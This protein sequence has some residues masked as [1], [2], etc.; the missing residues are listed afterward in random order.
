MHVQKV[1]T[2]FHGL[3]K[4]RNE[5]SLTSTGSSVNENPLARL[6]PCAVDERRVAR[7]HRHVQSRRGV[8]T[9]RGRYL[10]DGAVVDLDL[11][12]VR[13]L[14]GAKDAGLTRDESAAFRDRRVGGDDAGELGARDP[15]EGRFEL[16]LA[17]DLQNCG[18]FVRVSEATLCATS[19]LSWRGL[20]IKDCV[21][22]PHVSW[23][24]RCVH[25]IGMRYAQLRPA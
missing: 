22:G 18:P 24:P 3:E 5:P 4:A 21:D 10:D 14:A 15:G 1:N 6:S 17:L 23:C 19:R 13:A 16:V 9:H 2:G 8:E 12:G 25:V 20:T 7:R 11:F